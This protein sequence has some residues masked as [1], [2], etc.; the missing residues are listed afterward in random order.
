MISGSCDDTYV[1]NSYALSPNYPQTYGDDIDCRW[2]ISSPGVNNY[3]LTFLNIQTPPSDILKVY[4]GQNIHGNHIG[5]YSGYRSPPRIVS[6]GSNM[7]LRFTSDSGFLSYNK[8]FMIEVS[9]KY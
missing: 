3:K 4:E 8:G 5:T 9:G 7:Y 2:L 1:Q 6:N